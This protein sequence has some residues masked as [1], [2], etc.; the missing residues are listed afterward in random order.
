MRSRAILLWVLP[1][2]VLLGLFPLASRGNSIFYSLG[3]QGLDCENGAFRLMLSKDGGPHYRFFDRITN[4]TEYHLKLVR[5]FEFEDTNGDGV[6]S[7]VSD[8]ILPPPISLQSG[9]W[10]FKDFT[11]EEQNGSIQE[12]Q[13]HL[14]GSDF[15]PAQTSL[16]IGLRHY[17]D[18]TNTSIV[19]FD[20]IISGWQW[21]RGNSGLCLAA[22]VGSSARGNGSISTPNTTQKSTM[23]GFESAF[24]SYP[25]NASFDSNFAQ[26]NVSVGGFPEQ[27][28]GQ[29]VLFCFPNFGDNQLS[30]DPTIG[31][32]E[33]STTTTTT[34]SS[35]TT[36]T[37]TTTRPPSSILGAERFLLLAAGTTAVVGVL[38][39][40][41]SRD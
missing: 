13:F 15:S 32:E 8:T 23:I 20:I 28:D 30:Y 39:L 7:Q 14:N 34:T 4:K 10:V 37:I 29:G 24:V 9:N 17:V 41:A 11:Y 12:L 18:A 38:V 21:S 1:L 40:A 33:L 35:P 2:T 16:K 31:L 6:Y 36:T 27:G 19:K 3:A 25:A 5:L 26:V 22:V